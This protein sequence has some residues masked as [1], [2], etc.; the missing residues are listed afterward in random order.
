MKSESTES[1][2][3]TQN[4]EWKPQR[5]SKIYQNRTRAHCTNA[6]RGIQ[7]AGVATSKE[8]S[9]GFENQNRY[10]TYTKMTT[11]H[12]RKKGHTQQDSG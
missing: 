3:P 1:L 5:T 8:T 12:N 7:Y 6:L 9:V 2:Q 4:N 11:S 10:N